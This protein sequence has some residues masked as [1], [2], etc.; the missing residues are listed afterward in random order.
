MAGQNN[1]GTKVTG[2]ENAGRKKAGHAARLF[3]WI[4]D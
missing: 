2:D 1:R 4:A 3:Q